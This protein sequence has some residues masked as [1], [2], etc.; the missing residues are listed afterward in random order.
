MSRRVRTAAHLGLVLLVLGV[1]AARPQP[2][3]AAGCEAVVAALNRELRPKI[4]AGELIAALRAL[5]ASHDRALPEQFVTKRQAQR[6]GW[7]PGM[8]LWSVA[9]LRGKSIG[10][11]VFG[12]R[13]GKL[14]AGRRRWR[15]AD[16]G[17]HGGHRGAKRL[18]FSDDGLRQVTVDHY[19]S[20]REVPRCD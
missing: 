11:D 10:G 17:Y 15:E 9:G 7:R 8:D 13:E 6:A 5:N 1:I 4:D 2:A 12:N 14:P 20:F 18:I 3:A 19:R 16:L